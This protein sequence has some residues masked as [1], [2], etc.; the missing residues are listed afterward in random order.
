M[1]TQLPSVATLASLVI[2]VLRNRGG[3]ASTA[4]IRAAVEPRF[5]D[6]QRSVKHGSG[7]GTELQYRLRW[8]LVHLRQRNLIERVAP[9]T[10]SL[11]D[12][13]AA[14]EAATTNN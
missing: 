1:A 12:A 9:R 7:P 11:R 14:S 2:E 13:G 5:T 4:E 6:E 3:R 8:S 10:W